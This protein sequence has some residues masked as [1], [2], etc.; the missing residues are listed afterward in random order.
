[1]AKNMIVQQFGGPSVLESIGDRI[2]PIVDNYL[3]SENGKHYSEI[4]ESVRTEK[5]LTLIK[6]KVSITDKKVK[7]DDYAKIMEKE[8]G[9]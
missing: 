4:H 9:K 8:F 5:V 6:E 7:Y 3:Q 1:M 2:D